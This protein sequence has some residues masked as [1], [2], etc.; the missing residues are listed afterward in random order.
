MSA[1]LVGSEMCI[2]DRVVVEAEVEADAQPPA[3][4]RAD[5]CREYAG[6]SRVAA[7]AAAKG[8]ARPSGSA[9]RSWRAASDSL[10]APR[11]AARAS[12]RGLA[13]CTP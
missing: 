2:R 4:A 3:R 10:P 5:P 6:A 9:G 1:S 11:C 8:L 7:R 12:T 13:R